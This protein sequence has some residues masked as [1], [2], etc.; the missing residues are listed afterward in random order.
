MPVPSNYSN[1]PVNYSLVHAA[2]AN[3]NIFARL[4]SAANDLWGGKNAD[5]RTPQ[6]KSD[7]CLQV[8]VV[9]GYVRTTAHEGII[10]VDQRRGMSDPISV[11]EGSCNPQSAS[12]IRQGG[13]Y[14]EALKGGSPF[15]PTSQEAE[16]INE[17][18]KAL[19]D[20]G[21]KKQA[22]GPKI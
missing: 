15:A 3:N 8:H 2:Y 17:G 13:H 18:I 9:S 14:Y 12:C 19:K 7:A 1:G 5:N 6:Q 4:A 20:P 22:Q 10:E 11:Q 16:L 21:C